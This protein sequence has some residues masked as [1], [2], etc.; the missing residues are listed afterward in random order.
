M[1]GCPTRTCG[2][3]CCPATTPPPNTSAGCSGQTC[4]NACTV[5]LSCSTPDGHYCGS[6]TFDSNDPNFEGWILGSDHMAGIPV[7]NASLSY[8]Q[9]R[10]AASFSA[11]TNPPQNELIFEVILCASS[12]RADLS[13]KSLHFEMTANPQQDMTFDVYPTLYDANNG[14]FQL[15]ADEYIEAFPNGWNTPQVPAMLG[16]YIL[17]ELEVFIKAPYTGTLFLDNV[18]F[19]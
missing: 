11:N 15:N 14:S 16:G 10:L 13:G 17:L 6:W 19:Q 8:N 18:R 1:C 9:G 7:S 12:N 5:A 3:T 4:T 2:S